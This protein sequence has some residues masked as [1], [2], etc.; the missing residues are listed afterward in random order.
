VDKAST[1]TLLVVLAA[2][3]FTSQSGVDAPS[4]GAVLFIAS[5]SFRA[6]LWKVTKETLKHIRRA[7]GR[8]A[9]AIE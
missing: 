7:E 2:F 5:P 4:A 8:R 6:L 1:L 3:L 9:T